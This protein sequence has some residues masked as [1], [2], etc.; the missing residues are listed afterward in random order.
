MKSISNQ[1]IVLAIKLCVQVIKNQK[2][3]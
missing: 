1:K 3:K 2:L